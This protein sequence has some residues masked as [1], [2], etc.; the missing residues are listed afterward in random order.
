MSRRVKM[1]CRLG[2]ET[3]AAEVRIRTDTINAADWRLQPDGTSRHEQL[4]AFALQW[5]AD[6]CELRLWTDD[7]HAGP[8]LFALRS[9]A[10]SN[11]EDVEAAR[12]RTRNTTK[13]EPV[14]PRICPECGEDAARREPWQQGPDSWKPNH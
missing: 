9:P 11:A 1:A 5:L 3:R 10:E 2:D 6:Q 8:Q 14:P 7:V 12:E 13:R 4:E